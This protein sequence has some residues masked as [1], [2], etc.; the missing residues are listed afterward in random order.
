MVMPKKRNPPPAAIHVPWLCL[1]LGLLILIVYS[2]SFTVPFLFDSEIIVKMDPRI[3]A[4]TFANAEQ[5]LTRDYWFPN[6][7]SVLYRPLTTFSYMFNYAI[8]GNGENVFGYHV[9][10]FLLHWA[11]ACLVLLIVHRLAGRLDIAAL[12]A[13]LFALHPVNTEA[14]TNVVGR[15][16]LLATFCV[17]LGG[18]CYLNKR[19]AA[20]AVV[21]C[22][23]VLAKET[24]LMLVG[25]VGLYDLLWEK[26]LKDILKKFRLEYLALLPGLLLIA[27]IRRWMMSTTMVFEDFFLDNPLVGAAPFQRFVTAMSA[28]GRS[29][30]LLIFPQTLSADYSFNQI[31]LFGTGNTDTDIFAWISLVAVAFLLAVAIYIRKRNKLLAWSILFFF[32]MLLPTSN[33][34]VTIGS[35]MAERFLY[36][37][38][39]GFCAVMAVLLLALSERLAS[40]TRVNNRF[41]PVLRWAL[42]IV[43]IAALGIRTLQRNSDWQDDVALWKSTVAASPESYKAHMTYGNTILADAER[44][45][46]P[47]AQVI[48][49]AIA[50]EELA[51]SIMETRPPLPLK[52]KS[53]MVYLHLAKDYRMKGQFLDDSGR[54]DEGVRY[55]ERSLE[56][57]GKAQD[58]D[59]VTNQEA[60]DFKLRRGV[61]AEEI[62]DAG[63]YLVYESLCFTYAKFGEWEKCESAAHYLQHIAP[64]Q[65]SGYELLGAAYFNLG[66]YPDAAAQFLAGLLVDS[67]KPNWLSS[68]SA[69]YEKLGVEPNPVTSEGTVFTLNKD[70]PFMR[71]QLNQAA[72]LVVRLHEEAKRPD[73]SRELRDRLIRQYSLAPEIFS[74]KS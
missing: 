16:D 64:Q 6:Q 9:I 46:V 55:Y 26:S 69:T 66:R 53:V 70:L 63:N 37:S 24:G 23:G 43:L 4:A 10:N 15:A 74:R 40:P 68:L 8:L 5:I 22:L 65:P 42:P 20:M 60:H 51:Q 18:W 52:W 17:L 28:I 34:I 36:L 44:N 35:I 57:L 54:H 47:L 21:G 50:Q 2:N 12:T 58:V 7:E 14:V 13:G 67:E 33:L 3:R 19:L 27:A 29:L 72:A 25:F 30:K 41:A 31:P 59:R 38:S 45:N 11:N 1:A 56:T 73:E 49:D 71:Q 48:D 62:A 32:V 61:P 39:I